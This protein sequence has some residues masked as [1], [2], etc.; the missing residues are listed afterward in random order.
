MEKSFW[1]KNWE[2][3]NTG[4]HNS[5][6]NELLLKHFEKFDLGEDSH[7]FVPL[8]GKTRDLIW[9]AMQGHQVTGVECSPLAVAGFFKES[10]FSFDKTKEAKFNRFTCKNPPIDILEGDFFDVN[11]DALGRVNFLYD[12]A[13]IVALPPE[14]RKKYTKVI[15][16]ILTPGDQMLLLTLEY[17]SPEVLGPPFPVTEKDVRSY[18]ENNFSIELL[19]EIAKDVDHPRFIEAG[20]TRWSHK[21]YKLVRV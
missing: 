1:I 13:S 12:R 21:V 15:T 4:F 14:L 17:D 7:I 19:E 6:Y 10:N 5:E 16:D 11:R 2:D 9:L 18:Y 20:I 8:C 3:N